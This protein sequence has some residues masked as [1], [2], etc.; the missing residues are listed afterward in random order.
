MSSLSDFDLSDF[1]LSDFNLSDFDLSDS[2]REKNSRCNYQSLSIR[3]DQSS[4]SR[5]DII[6]SRYDILPYNTIKV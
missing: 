3:E 5:Y 1:D 4:N 6:L 2:F